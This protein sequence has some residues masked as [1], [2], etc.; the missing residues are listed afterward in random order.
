MPD[1]GSRWHDRAVDPIVGEVEQAGDE[2]SVAG[3]PLGLLRL[4]V[5]ARFAGGRR[6]A[7][8]HETTLGTDR[9]DHRVLHLLGLDQ[10]EDLGAEVLG[11]VRPPQAAAGYRAES[12]VHPFQSRRVHPDLMCGNGFRHTGDSSGVQLEGQVRPVLPA[13]VSLVDVGPVGGQNH[14]QVDPHDP[15]RVQAGDVVESRDHL[16]GEVVAVRPAGHLV[17][18]RIEPPAEQLEQ[19]PGDV[20]VVHQHPLQISLRVGGSELPQVMGVSPE[21]GNL[22]PVEAGGE[23]Q[24]VEPV[25]R[26]ITAPTAD[27]RLG[28]PGLGVAR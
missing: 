24:P 19:K 11:P 26:G 14:R 22:A 17:T 9:H 5:G 6:W 21:H 8:H 10:A 1:H 23:H 25:D 7:A 20:G 15:V 16:L 13:R 3:D 4:P 12:E 2:Q 28:Q 18:R 27:E